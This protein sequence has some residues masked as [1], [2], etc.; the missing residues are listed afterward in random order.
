MNRDEK[1]VKITSV[2]R[3]EA[4]GKTV[5]LKFMYSVVYSARSYNVN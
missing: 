3:K 4:T 2:W 5:K 1:P